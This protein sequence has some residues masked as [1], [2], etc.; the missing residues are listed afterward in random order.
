LVE[1]LLRSW[2]ALLRLAISCSYLLSFFFI[3]LIYHRIELSQDI[4]SVKFH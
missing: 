4:S 2:L 1:A 3:E